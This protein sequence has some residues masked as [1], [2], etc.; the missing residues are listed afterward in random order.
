MYSLVV[1]AALSGCSSSSS[2]SSTTSPGSL[3]GIV[4]LGREVSG[5]SP[6]R[7]VNSSGVT[8]SLDGT[9]IS[10]QTD[11][12]GYWKLTN[13][14][15]GNY[16]VTITKPGF[17]LTRIY[18][19]YIGGPG[20]AFIPRIALGEIPPNAPQLVSAEIKTIVWSDTGKQ[21]QRDDLQI[22]WTSS[23]D[24]NYS[25]LSVFLDKEATVQSADTHFYIGLNGGQGIWS[26]WFEGPSN[27]TTRPFSNQ[28][29]GMMSCP[30]ETLHA[31]GIT[32]GMKVYISLCQYDPFGVNGEAP[33]DNIT[34]YDPIHNQNHL[35]S[36]TPRSNVVAI[37]MP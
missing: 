6:M 24:R 10:T 9:S 28:Y 36:P 33:N 2:P 11:S 19:V 37:T 31:Q 20:T 5:S 7:Y 23:Y 8:V 25:G 15:G 29:N 35:I 32:S 17:G 26:G 18:G 4:S 22:R 16:D 14:A 21:H 12:S 27:D 13:V 34:Y 1:L 3:S 30:I